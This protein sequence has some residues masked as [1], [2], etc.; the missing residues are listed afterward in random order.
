M[1]AAGSRRSRRSQAWA[2]PL[3]SNLARRS[4]TAFIRTAP[5]AQVL[6]PSVLDRLRLGEG[7]E[8]RGQQL[9]ERFHPALQ[10]DVTLDHALHDRRQDRLAHVLADHVDD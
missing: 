3:S 6:L 4:A 8:A 10:D 2:W 7:L 1:R 5:A 9:L